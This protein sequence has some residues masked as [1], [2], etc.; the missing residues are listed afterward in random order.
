MKLGIKQ[1]N[2]TIIQIQKSKQNS[3]QVKGW[4]TGYR[5]ILQNQTKLGKFQE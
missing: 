5:M 3:S 2:K 4:V 1:L